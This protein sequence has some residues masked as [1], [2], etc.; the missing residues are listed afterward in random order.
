M[1]RSWAAGS[2]RSWRRIRQLVLTRDHHRCRLTLP[3]C[4]TTAT[5]A[6]HLTG[7]Q[8]GDD[9]AL[10]VAAC[11]PCNRRTGSPLAGNPDPRPVTRW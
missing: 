3:G 4:T 7:K 11:G 1:S 5:E 8:S 9:P 2:T 10:L 6:H